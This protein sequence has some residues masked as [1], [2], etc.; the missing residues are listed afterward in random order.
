MDWLGLRFTGALPE[1]GQML[2]HCTHD[3][4]LVLLAYVVACAGSFATLDIAERLQQAEH[5]GTRRR[6]RWA[7]AAC[8]AG[9]IWG[10]HFIS[11]LAFM[12]PMEVHY[13]LPI[14][15]VSLL[16]AL[17]ASLATLRSLERA[18]LNGGQYLQA[19]VILGLGIVAMHYYGMSAMRSNAQTY[20]DP[21]LFALSIVIA[22]AVSFAALVLTR[23]F[24]YPSGRYAELRKY[25][26]T[27]LMAAGIISTHFTGMWALTM[28]M[29]VDL[30]MHGNVTSNGTQLGIT[31]AAITLLI[32]ALC[33]NA[34]LADKKL[35]S[36]EQDLRHATAMLNQLD[37]AQ[38]SLQQAAHY[39][40]LTN[41]VNRRGFDQLFADK[42]QER[43]AT[44]GMLAVMFLDIDHFKRI[45]DSLGHDAG[46]ELL[47]A[48]ANLLRNATRGQDD[49]V[50]R[51]GGDEFCVL[52]SL[53][54]R[55]EARMM[56]QRIM[57]AMKNPIELAGRRMVMTTSIGISLFPDDGNSTEALLKNADL[58]L[59]QSKGN[60]RN[61]AH[62]FSEDLRSK[63]SMA[64][65]LEAEL[66]E[67]LRGGQELE[68]FYQPIFDLRSGQV[69]RLEAL[70]RWR[71]PEHGLLSPDAF[72]GIAE[73]NGLIAEL[74]GWVLH[75]ACLDLGELERLGHDKLRIAL[76]CSALNLK[77]ESLVDEIAKALADTG[78]KPQRLELEVTE[79]AVMLNIDAAIKV[80]SSIEALGVSLVIDDFG[81]GYSSLAYLKR[82]PLNTLKIDRSFIQN[83]SPAPYDMQVVKAI[84][85]M[86]HT[87][88]MQVITEGVETE[89]QYEMLK[90]YG[91][92]FAQG[93]LLGHPV[94]M[95]QLRELLGQVEKRPPPPSAPPPT[96]SIVGKTPNR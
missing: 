12:A 86:A 5:P 34:A 79:N 36:K 75:R 92:D 9:G 63:A 67:A 94:P 31:V 77:R 3:P 66:R 53:R 78:A 28:A 80:L 15:I 82:L 20:Y 1:Q 70:V 16:I 11:M 51:F 2:L 55:D 21:W 32:M 69:T 41:L 87:L 44:G 62:F 95:A 29:P 54:T 73:T 58:A 52:L 90:Q 61:S 40:G 81:T 7:G 96:L 88:G 24:R 30:H 71:H 13:D 65:H 74:D 46:D 18:T 38:V 17:I 64:L 43:R 10:M 76:N 60:G 19:A 89:E 83:T 45:N 37:Q 49:V 57:T 27:L 85:A 33:I 48:I 68:L 22:I 59:Y 56:A 50:A 8:L 14:T 39:D 26:A 93:F 84:I 25:A 4:F 6:W 35:Q 47:K 91:C 42:L 23:R 72:I